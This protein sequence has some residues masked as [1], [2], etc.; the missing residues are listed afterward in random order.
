MILRFVSVDEMYVPTDNGLESKV[1]ICLVVMVQKHYNYVACLIC[2]NLEQS[3]NV[4][5]KAL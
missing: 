5:Y 4:G 1:S 2:K 3:C